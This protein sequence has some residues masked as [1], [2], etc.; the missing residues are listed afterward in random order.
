MNL[1]F[2]SAG[3]RVSLIRSF[4]AALQKLNLDGRIVT[5]DMGRTAPAAFVSDAHEIV[6]RVTDPA[7]IPALLDI[8]KACRIRMVIPLIDTELEILSLHKPEFER[9]GV[10]LLVSS[11]ETVRICSDKRNTGRFFNDIGVGTPKVYDSDILLKASELPFPLLIKPADGSSSKGVTKIRNRKEL[12]F[13]L[14]YI[15]NAIVQEFV[16]GQEYTLDAWVDFAGKV[17]SVVPRLRM[18]TRAGEV[19]KGMTVKNLRLIEKTKYV[20]ESLPG[21]VGCIT[22]QCFVTEQGDIKFTEINPR[23]GGGFPLSCAAGADF[24]KWILQDLLGQR[25]EEEWNNWKD[26]VV[27]LRYDEEIIVSREDIQ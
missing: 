4:R 21:A 7:Y 15:P 6:P 25:N 26:G 1:L 27:M 8:C 12:E 2:T 3:R 11:P 13:F 20:V 22:V 24:P 5:A 17:R 9:L 18:E 16:T 23:F 10:T 19:S 14:D